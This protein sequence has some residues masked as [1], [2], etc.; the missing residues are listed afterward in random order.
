M[1][2]LNEI[3]KNKNDFIQRYKIMGKAYNID[4][5]VNLEEKFI[6]IDSRKNANRAKCNKL[7]S[8]VADVI[9]NGQNVDSLINEI[10][11]LDKSVIKDEIKS[12]KAMSKINKLLKK[13]PNPA[14]DDNILNLSLKT[15]PN[16]NFGK[17]D[18]IQELNNI[19][20][21]STLNKI[22]TKKFLSR[23]K[24]R[25]LKIENLPLIFAYEK[26]SNA[27]FILLL[28]DSAKT[29]Y[30]KLI[31]ILANNA[32]YVFNK[33]IKVLN[34]SSSKEAKVILCD[35]TLINIQ[36]TGEYIS[37]EIGLKL[38]DKNIDMTKFINIIRI[39]VKNHG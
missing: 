24:N 13:L 39:Q 15:T 34:K 16:Q 3:L 1:I 21:P 4:K 7:C 2:A 25:V 19:A 29:Q 18:F 8:Q 26:K 11:N 20:K 30:D 31:S 17:K 6:E 37:R 35:G 23:V 32:Q 36:F 33:T 12:Q 14:I 5:I 27:E 22:T 38:Y 10:N 9:N 28:D